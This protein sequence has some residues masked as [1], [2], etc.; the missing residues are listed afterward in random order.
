MLVWEV[1]GGKGACAELVKV[2][3]LYSKL[4]LAIK[5]KAKAS[6]SSSS[7]SFLPRPVPPPTASDCRVT[8]GAI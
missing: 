2:I 8:S 3:K 4:G 1:D 5:L 6:S 7:S